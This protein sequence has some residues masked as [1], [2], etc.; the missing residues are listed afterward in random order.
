MHYIQKKCQLYQLQLYSLFQKDFLVTGY[1][2]F[3]KIKQLCCKKSTKKF[4]NN[5]KIIYEA[6]I[7]QKIV[8]MKKL[9]DIKIN[10]V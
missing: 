3:T 8:N 7:Y 1:V 6:K 4:K 2:Y 10:Y 9:L 5:L